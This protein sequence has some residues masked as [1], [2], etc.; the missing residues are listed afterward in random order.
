[1]KQIKTI[2]TRATIY[3]LISA[4]EK[5]LRTILQIIINYS[6]NS[7]IDISCIIPDEIMEKANLRQEKELDLISIV[8]FF[9]FSEEIDMISK[10]KNYLPNKTC[11]VFT[12]SVM[13]ELRGLIP[14]RNRVMH[15]RPLEFEDFQSTIDSINY[16]LDKDKEHCIFKYL[17]KMFTRLLD[18]PGLVLDYKL[19]ESK[20]CTD[21][22]NNL[23][24]PDYDDTG[25]IGRKELIQNI[26]T[27]CYG[28][29]PVVTILGDGGLG[30]TAL[31]LEVA[32]QILDDN[33]DVFDAI[34]WASSKTTKITSY[35]IT[36]ISESIRNSFDLFD[37]ISKNLDGN[38]EDSISTILKYLAQFR[39]LLII[40]NLETIIDQTIIDFLGKLPMGSK[41]L[42]TSRIGLG[43]FEYII[44]IDQL[45]SFDSVKLLRT[46]AKIRG[47]SVLT[48]TS[49]NKIK[50]YCKKMGNNPGFIKWFVSTVGIG[51]SP[52]N[53]LANSKYFLEFCM[54]NVYDYIDENSRDVLNVLLSSSKDLTLGEINFISEKDPLVLQE[55]IQKLIT[56]NMVN[57]DNGKYETIYKI[58][59]FAKNF[60]SSNNKID[61][62]QYR[63]YR[64]RINK[65][66]NLNDS[67]LEEEKKYNYRNI[68][69]RTN[70]DK[71]I[72]L[73]L[74][75]VLK[76]LEK[77]R[78]DEAELIIKRVTILS[79]EYFEVHR[80][81]AMLKEK[82][83]ASSDAHEAYETA[84]RLSPK[85][86]Q[87]YY[88]LG[89]FIHK[90]LGNSSE[91]II[92]FEKAIKLDQIAFEPN[93]ELARMYIFTQDYIKANEVINKLKGLDLKAKNI[94]LVKYLEMQI[95][96]RKAE[97]YLYSEKEN[98]ILL[99]CQYLQSLVKRYKELNYCDLTSPMKKLLI[100]AD[101]IIFSLT[102]FSSTEKI[103]DKIVKSIIEDW[104]SLSNFEQRFIHGQICSL[105][106][107]KDSVYGY[108]LDD[109]NVSFYFRK[110]W[111]Y[112]RDIISKLS[113]GFDVLFIPFKDKENRL[114]SR[115]IK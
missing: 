5:D 29:Y 83:S 90:T 48:K 3:V 54:S 81:K 100:K 57:M 84:I 36:D 106:N 97:Y 65:L 109:N 10:N 61:K 79:P 70:N 80:I 67:N 77:N 25:Y 50:E 11:K 30:K 56:T 94:L 101:S 7:N 73:Q 82:E 112:N 40:D 27:V 75:E 87:L 4:L 55:A 59:E 63:R 102:R 104:I 15:S 105:S 21:I 9:D 98:N 20:D 2:Y 66:A 42:I 107:E 88:F 115:L 1:M 72:K 45:D 12:D 74:V 6:E 108:I 14:V 95:D 103:D 32:Y 24:I 62:N 39:I 89:I 28:P 96:Y 44:K 18:N 53:V 38:C 113:T 41:V 16:F 33:K 114:S 110:E 37:E 23:P 60:L 13:L 71:A 93:Y 43:Q 49:T 64:K 52:E 19:P 17:L 26:K 35:E 76:A 46:Y 47:V 31:A 86:S 85:S 78:L 111:F 58:T 51:K 22:L 68:V 91:A 8:E 34:I 69:L 99:G 92:Q